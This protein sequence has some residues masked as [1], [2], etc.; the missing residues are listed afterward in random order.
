MKP[1]VRST[2]LRTLLAAGL[3]TLLPV[4]IAVGAPAAQLADVLSQGRV[5]GIG[6]AT[7]LQSDRLRATDVLYPPALLGEWRLSRVVSGVEGDAGQAETAWR[8]LG[9]SGS[10]LQPETH[11]VRFIASPRGQIGVVADRGFEYSQRTGSPVEWAV[12]RPDELRASTPGGAVTL[13][14]VQRTIE[15]YQPEPPYGFGASEL[16]RI[17][18]PAGGLMGSG[19]SLQRAVKVS[20]RYR[21]ADDGID[22]LEIV[23]TYRVM[24]GVAGTEMPTSTTK[25]RLKLQRQGGGRDPQ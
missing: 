14:V 13:D 19:V 8:A 7:D 17:T 12:A 18:S 16:V 10:F 4:R 20:R 24:D 5:P 3:T 2:A 21:P 1:I 23:K 25:S 15:P 22:V 6:G 9:G 11:S